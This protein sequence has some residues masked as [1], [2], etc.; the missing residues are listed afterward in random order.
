MSDTKGLEERL[1]N[2]ASFVEPDD[3]RLL[4][5]TADALSQLRTQVEGLDAANVKLR[6]GLQIGYDAMKAAI[7]KCQATVAECLSEHKDV[8]TKRLAIF[9][10]LDIPLAQVGCTLRAS[11]EALAAVDQL[12]A[13]ADFVPPS[14]QDEREGK[15]RRN[16]AKLTDDEIAALGGVEFIMGTVEPE[17]DRER[18]TR[19][20]ER[21]RCARETNDAMKVALHVLCDARS[22]RP[23]PSESM[24][25]FD[26]AI[27][28]LRK[29]LE[30][31][32]AIRQ[33]RGE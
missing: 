8:S 20:E 9:R 21:E 30:P 14:L 13:A 31:L 15:V 3:T 6:E 24:K 19:E 32:A 18:A 33:E 23:W 26:A 12:M 25:H 22:S 1:R 27:Y 11:N 17:P 28:G 5:E 2:R 10:D 29:Q 16:D 7:G 4:L